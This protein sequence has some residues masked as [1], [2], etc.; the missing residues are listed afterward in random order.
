LSLYVYHLKKIPTSIDNSPISTYET[1]LESEHFVL[2]ASKGYMK[3]SR[4]S[5]LLTLA[6]LTIS[7][8]SAYL[9]QPPLDGKVTI[10]LMKGL[11]ISRIGAT[12]LILWY[13]AREGH[14][15]IAHELTHILMGDSPSRLL[16][17]GLAVY[18]QDR[19][20]DYD[21]PILY[22][23]SDLATLGQI[24]RGSFMPLDNLNKGIGFQGESRRL[25]YVESGSFAG[26]LISCFG[27][28]KY[29]E[30]Y[31]SNDYQEVYGQ[32]LGE[33]E[34]GWIQ[35]LWW[36]NLLVTAI[37]M[38]TGGLCL[39]AM[40]V[41]LTKESPWWFLFVAL[42]P[43]ALAVLDLFLYFR[44]PSILTIV[45]TILALLTVPL[46]GK[47]P[48]KWTRLVI[49]VIGSLSLSDRACISRRELDDCILIIIRP[50][51]D[52]RITIRD[53]GCCGIWKQSCMIF[54]GR[55]GS[56]LEYPGRSAQSR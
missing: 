2:K 5:S 52:V 17:E 42:I 50:K 11:G 31:Y 43:Q 28:P 41:A 21:F 38:I 46:D 15:P 26:Y 55:K 16:R 30:I 36:K 48:T 4:L 7:D 8:L 14:A 33:L 51:Y 49:W 20:G 3:E 35:Q 24:R 39:Y 10:Y 29:K 25:T 54:V 9:D 12:R 23:T 37:Y 34:R 32:T 53:R 6:E 22:S 27:L 18:N 13:M 45:Y 44:F 1:I 40:S 19:F 56:G 47:I